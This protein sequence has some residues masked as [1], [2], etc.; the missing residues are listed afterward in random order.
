MKPKPVKDVTADL[1]VVIDDQH[2]LAY[3]LQ[4][5]ATIRH[6]QQLSSGRM[7]F[8]FDRTE[9]NTR[10]ERAFWADLDLQSYVRSYQRGWSL[11]QEAKQSRKGG[12]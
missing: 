8:C 4:H 2:L 1:F 7:A 5:G 6:S 3:F 12:H 9:E 10:L 11:I